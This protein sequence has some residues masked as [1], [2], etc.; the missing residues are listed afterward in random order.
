[1]YKFADTSPAIS[2]DPDLSA[3]AITINGIAIERDIEGFR[4]LTVSGRELIPK[5]LTTKVIGDSDGDIKTSARLPNRTITVKYQI[6]SKSPDEYRKKFY[7]LNS[8]LNQGE[9]RLEFNDAKDVHFMGEFEATNTPTDGKINIISTFAFHC[10]Q[11]FAY[12]NVEKTFTN[13]GNTIT[14]ENSG[15][16]PTPVSF[17]IEH[18]SDN[19]FIGLVNPKSVIQVGNPDEIDG[20]DYSQNE[21][22]LFNDFNSPDELTK[23]QL[24]KIQPSY[25]KPKTLGGSFEVKPGVNGDGSLQVKDYAGG[26]DNT[27]WYGPSI[28]RDLEPNSNGDNTAGNFLLK[29][30]VQAWANTPDD[31][32]VHE[33]T[34]M[35]ENMKPLCGFYFRKLNW[36]TYDMQ[37]YMFVRDTIVMKWEGPSASLMRD[38]LGNILIEKNG[39]DFT[40][41]VTNQTNGASGAYHLHDEE[42]GKAK[43]KGVVYWTGRAGKLA[44]FDKQLFWVEIIETV[45]K[46]NDS[47]NMFS[48]A[49]KVTIDCTDRTVK[50]YLNGSQVLDIMNIGSRPIIA[51]PGESVVA[52][53][54][55]TFAKPLKVTAKIRERWL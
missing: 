4:T 7:R 31:Y 10:Y 15:T 37:L 44:T 16:Y 2:G 26:D 24:N 52:V 38:F 23:W 20:Y 12:A 35:D 30:L 33:L 25:Y 48:K 29:S 51:P 18:Q 9:S 47:K 41:T 13:V 43:A 19:G 55:S 11:P 50:P 45:G 17:E 49:D 3:E 46:W 21:S 1:M 6:T 27:M 5:L 36:A 32:G 53:A 42:A 8:L 39:A 40:F 34:V 28:Y 54:S 14:I 22:R